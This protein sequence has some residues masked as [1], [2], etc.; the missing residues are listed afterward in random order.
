MHDNT[1]TNEKDVYMNEAS[2]I[3]EQRL[4]LL[5]KFQK[6]ITSMNEQSYWVHVYIS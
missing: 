4:A 5:K 1:V 2:L 3:R 6:D